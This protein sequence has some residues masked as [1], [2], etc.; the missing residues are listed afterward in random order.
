MAPWQP[1]LQSEPDVVWNADLGAYDQ[2]I[3]LTQHMVNESFRNIWKKV[4]TDANHPMRL[5]KA[6]SKRC[7]SIEAQLD[8]PPAMF[9][10]ESSDFNEVV[11][12]MRYDG[13]PFTVLDL[14]VLLILL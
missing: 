4:E 6:K 10:V 7:G 3:A 2:V 13:F 11:Y 14:N 5:F 1:D 9:N 12:V 8:S